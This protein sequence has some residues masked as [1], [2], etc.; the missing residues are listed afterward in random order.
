MQRHLLCSLVSFL[1]LP[2][3]GCGGAQDGAASPNTKSSGAN[4]MV[5]AEVVGAAIAP[6]KADGMSWDGVPAT[7]IPPE[8]DAEIRK[9]LAEPEGTKKVAPLLAKLVAKGIEPPDPQGTV[10]AFAG[11]A[12][13]GAPQTLPKVQDTFTPTWSSVRIEH[14]KLDDRARLR[15]HIEDA[16]DGGGDPIGDV[17]MDATAMR[18]ALAKGKPTD[19][20]FDSKSPHILYLTIAIRAE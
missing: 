1:F 12:A 18:D 3:V 8:A 11:D 19:V 17:D 6:G 14:L 10:Q 15:V 16:D 13:Q 20:R 9:A 4:P 5:T 7:K 2:L